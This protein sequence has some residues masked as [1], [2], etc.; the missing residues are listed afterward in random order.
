MKDLRNTLCD[1][2]YLRLHINTKFILK[3]FQNFIKISTRFIK[4]HADC[5]CE[6]R[7]L[8]IDDHFVCKNCKSSMQNICRS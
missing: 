2:I 6:S 4:I 1:H 8:K 7:T 3:Y 5:R